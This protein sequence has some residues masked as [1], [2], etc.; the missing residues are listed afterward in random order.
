M[1]IPKKNRIL[2]YESLFKH[3]VL[4]AKKD[5]NM[6]KHHELETVRNLEV[7]KAMQ[8]SRVTILRSLHDCDGIEYL[9][10]YLHLP[11]EIVPATLRR[12]P[13]ADSGRARPRATEP[14][15]PSGRESDR[16]QY[17]RGGQ[18][19]GKASGA[20]SDFNPEFRGASTGIG[21][22]FGPPPS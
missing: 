14:R 12:Q 18:G 4:V 20:G 17:R 22:G 10:E 7:I 8:V 3:G 21:R 16:E 15:S 13:K 2:I 19:E 6:P 11:P 5:Y 9:R 1:F